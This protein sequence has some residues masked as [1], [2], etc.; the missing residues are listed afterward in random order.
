MSVPEIAKK[1]SVSIWAT[2]SFF[3][4]NKMKRRTQKEERV[5]RFRNK[6]PSFKRKN[7]DS[8]DGRE[9]AVVGAMLYWAEG[10]KGSDE[11]PAKTLDFAN[12][13]PRMISLFLLF[14][15]STYIF[16]ESRIRLQLYCYADQDVESISNFWCSLTKIPRSQLTKPYVRNDFRIDGPKMKYGLIHVRY[17]DMKLVIDIKSMIDC[18]VQKYA[19]IV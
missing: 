6:K 1:L 10:Y 4:R 16:D 13:D 5:I 8:D 18:Y 7:V 3:R 14:M 12:S 15:R 2:Y 17:S 11:R 19:P 9:L